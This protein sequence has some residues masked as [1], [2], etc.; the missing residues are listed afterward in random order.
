MYNRAEGEFDGFLVNGLISTAI[1]KHACPGRKKPVEAIHMDLL[2]YYRGLLKIAVSSPGI[3]LEGVCLDFMEAGSIRDRIADGTI[4]DVAEEYCTAVE[5]MSLEELLNQ[6]NLLMERIRKRRA[7]GTLDLVVT[8]FSTVVEEL[9]KEQIPCCFIFPGR[10][11]IEEV[12]GRL[13][14]RLDMKRMRESFPAVIRVGYGRKKTDYDELI[15]VNLKR[16]LLEF[17]RDYGKDFVVQKRDRYFEVFTSAGTLEQ[18]TGQESGCPL[19][20]YLEHALGDVV[21]IGYGIGKNVVQARHGALDA[22]RESE[23]NPA[24]AS[25]LIDEEERLMGPLSEGERLVLES[26]PSGEHLRMAEKTGISPLTLQ[27]ICAVSEAEEDGI[28]TAQLL[29]DKLGLTVRA[30]SKYLQK[31]VQGGAASGLSLSGA[32]H[33]GRPELLVQIVGLPGRESYSGRNGGNA[34]ERK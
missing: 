17:G 25:Y 6:K 5:N 31:L 28:I 27:K 12:A 7:A 14:M 22:C 10:T 19:K 18:I 2:S 3:R 29:A 15:E 8:R 1:L 30:T 23:S 26:R 16:A 4:D 33:A 13:L 20:P 24:G 11:Y 34:E 32:C 21:R 9:E